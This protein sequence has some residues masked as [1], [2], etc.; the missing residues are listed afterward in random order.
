MDSPTVTDRIIS[1][2]ELLNSR[3]GQT[4]SGPQVAKV[5]Y[6]IRRMNDLYGSLPAEEKLALRGLLEATGM[7]PCTIKINTGKQ[8]SID[9]RPES[10]L[11]SEEVMLDELSRSD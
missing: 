4:L 8:T 6:Y 10:L 7:M 11:K 5:R 9:V 3:D 1:I 2:L